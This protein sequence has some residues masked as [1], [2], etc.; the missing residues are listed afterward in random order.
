MNRQTY[1]NTLKEHRIKHGLRQVDVTHFLGF[2]GTDRISFWEQG[3]ALPSLPNL[4]KL[5]VLYRVSPFELYSDLAAIAEG[6]VE[7]RKPE[8]LE[9]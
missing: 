3:K 4:F 9:K 2:T 5:C 1:N 7:E 6:D 8:I